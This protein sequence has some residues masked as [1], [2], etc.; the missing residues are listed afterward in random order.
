MLRFDWQYESIGSDNDMA[1]DRRQ[2][3][4]WTNGSLGHWLIYVSLG[5]DELIHDVLNYFKMNSKYMHLMSMHYIEHLKFVEVPL[6][7]HNVLPV[8]YREN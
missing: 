3:I 2:D 1:P 5:L 8:V 7:K 6:K 4:I